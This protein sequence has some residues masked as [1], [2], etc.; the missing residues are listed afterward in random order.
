[1]SAEYDYQSQV[2][3]V[4]PKG[5]E[6][7]GPHER[8]GKPFTIFTLWFGANV[9]FATL[10][11]GALA[12]GV[13]GLS[14]WQAALAIVIGNVLG[15]LALGA[16]STFGPKHGV[17]QLI[18]SRKAFGYY[19]NFIPGILNFIAGFSWFA[20]NTVLGVYALEWLFH[21]SF[22]LGLVIMAIIQIVIAVYG[23]NLIHVLERYLAIVLTVVFLIV[24]IY[25]FANG[26]ISAPP[27]LKLASEVG[28]TTGAFMLTL[29]IAFSYC[30]GWM[31]FASDYTRYLP[32]KT[33]AR[34][35]FG[36]A[37]WSLLIAGIWLEV[38]G[39][40]LATL[41]G[42]FVPTD[43][44]THLLPYS[45]GVVTMIA[46]VL[47]TITANVLN[48][49]SGA[50]SSLVIDIPMKRWMSAVVVG[51]LG[52]L[53]AWYASQNGTFF[54]K[55]QTFLFLLGYWVAPWLAIVLV[56]YFVKAKGDYATSEFYD[57][58]RP[59][60]M[61]FWAWI[62]GVLVSVPFMNQYGMFVGPF[63][64]SHPQFGDITYF[65][66]F[67]VAG[68]IYAVFAQPKRKAA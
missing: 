49:Y 36:N 65:V 14:F 2:L 13:F 18:Q 19:G 17:P 68:L 29:A 32:E 62:V 16:L 30:L 64:S 41:K 22:G 63:A 50:L 58:K 39:A 28:G 38:L 48:I 4:E 26:H 53:V 44:V 33:S 12:T 21:M 66:G 5:I 9:E 1:M 15:A 57:R 40:A 10:V 54:S 35:V 61:G 8:H 55:Y 20:V 24:T 34:A 52:T 37:F 47:G 27:N 56:D 31:A 25:G 45:L 67:L 42:I 59:F 7:I 11:T 60:G 51:V 46:V 3:K 43:L 23:Y 6:P